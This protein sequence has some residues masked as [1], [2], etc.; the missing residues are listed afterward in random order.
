VVLVNGARQCGKSTLVAQVA[1]DR[2]LAWYSLDQKTAAESAR[3]DPEG[4]VRS[5]PA[6][7]IDEIQRD[8]GLILPIKSVVDFDPTPG[9]FLL[10]GSSRLA[11]MRQLP[12]TL[13]GRMETIELWPLSQGEIDSEPDGFVDAAFRDGPDLAIRGEETRADYIERVVRGGFPEAVARQGRRRRAFHQQYAAD[14]VNRDVKQVG[15]VEFNPALRKLVRL[16]AA[17]SAGILSMDSLASDLGV[18]G[19][20]VSRY[21]SLLEQVFLIKQIPAWAP[22]ASTRAVKAPKVVFVDSGLATS[23][24]PADALQLGTAQGPLGGI[25]EGFVVTELARQ[26]TWCRQEVELFHYRTR[27]KV[28]VDVVLRDL[29]GR[30]V[31]IEVKASSTARSEDFKGLRHLRQR[32]GDKFVAGYLIY[33]GQDTLPMGDRLRTLPLCALWRAH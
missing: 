6:M 4:F 26:L 1:R 19:R 28:E 27:D 33:L 18:S 32:L 9:H 21:L 17:R 25:L 2:G 15:E 13:P 16:L 12:D 8:L 10:T 14:L 29:A 30:V 11:G 23:L 24:V 31:G 7:V 3:F 20:T 5:A 22:S